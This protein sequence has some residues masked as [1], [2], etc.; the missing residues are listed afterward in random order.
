MSKGSNKMKF[1]TNCGC[2][3]NDKTIVCP[4]CGMS[5]KP[6]EDLADHGAAVRMLIPVDRSLLA[7]FAGYAG[8][9]SCIPLVGIAAILLGIFAIKDIKAHP[10]MHGLGRAW[11]GIVLGTLCTILHICGIFFKS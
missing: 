11:T 2:Q 7:I 9:A 6:N 8:L 4:K 10:N 1:C 3:L 5:I